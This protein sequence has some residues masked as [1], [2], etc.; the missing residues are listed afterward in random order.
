MVR[1]I[2]TLGLAALVSVTLLGACSSDD[3]NAADD[4]SVSSC[5]ADPGG[6][7]PSAD[8]NI[9]NNSSKDSSYAFRVVFDDTSGN[10]VSNGAVTV[11]E[12]KPGATATWHADGVTS[13]KGALTCKVTNV[14]RTARP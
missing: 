8:G 12:V 9:K 3:K 5:K 10:E 2:R 6:G 7:R 14:V 1:H 11:S 4:V 13:A